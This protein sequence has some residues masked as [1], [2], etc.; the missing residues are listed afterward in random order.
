[1]SQRIRALVY[2]AFDF[3]VQAWR[4]C[5]VR[6]RGALLQSS[7]PSKDMSSSPPELIEIFKRDLP[8][9]DTQAMINKYYLSGSAFALDDT[10][11]HKLREEVAR[12]FRIDFSSIFMVGS[13]KL[14][15]SIKPERRFMYFGDQSDVDVVIISEPL[16]TR[17]WQEIHTFKENGGYWPEMSTF[18]YYHFQGWMRPDK[19]PRAPSFAFTSEWWDFFNSFSKDGR[20]G[21]Y[22]IRAALYHSRFFFDS[23][24]QKCLDQCRQIL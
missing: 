4:F 10:Q 15:F 2:A 20:C 19:L 3:L 17:A 9:L 13:A 18:A 12:Y 6:W 24:Q 23:Y 14:G 16:F 21:P 1:M 11:H 7:K 8:K 5:N 22:R